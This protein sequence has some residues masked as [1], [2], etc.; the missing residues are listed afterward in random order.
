MNPDLAWAVWSRRAPAADRGRA[1]A[2]A[3]GGGRRAGAAQPGDALRG[4]RTAASACGR[5]SPTRPASSPA[6]R[7]PA[8]TRAAAAVE[9]DPRLFARPRRPAVHGRRHAAPRQADLPRRVRR[10]DGAARRR[11]AAGARV[12]RARRA[13][14][15]PTARGAC[16]LLA[17]AAGVRG[18][19]G[20][21]AIDLDSVGATLC[22]AGARNDA[23]DEDGRADPR[24]RAAGRRLRP[25]A[26]R[27]P[28]R[29][30]STPTPTRRV[31][32]SRSSTTCS[33]S[34]ARRRRSARPPARTS[35]R[36]SRPSSRCLGLAGGQAARGGAARRSA[37]RRSPRSAAPRAGSPSSPTGSCCGRTRPDVSAARPDRR[38]RRRC[39]ASTATRCRSSRASCARSC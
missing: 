25:A 13:A 36:A 18:M 37:A 34:K 10:G 38:S 29:R 28:K 19:A 39:A 20:G 26:R 7:P 4:A 5:C 14:A 6:R 27:A 8:S 3:A 2:R 1:R 33:T 31:S 12:R 17:E 23:P 30:R 21:Q 35:R 15:C 11:R 9:L 22:A 16:A 32:P 24:R